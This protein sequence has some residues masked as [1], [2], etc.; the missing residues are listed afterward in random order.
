MFVL[1]FLKSATFSTNLLKKHLGDS[2]FHN[3]EEVKMVT[4]N[5][6][7]CNSQVPIAKEF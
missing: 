2:R 5:D 1:Q 7:K 3:A 4:M 6:C